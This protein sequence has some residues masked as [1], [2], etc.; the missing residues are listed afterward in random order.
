MSCINFSHCS[1]RKSGVFQ[2]KQSD[3]LHMLNYVEQCIE[4]E[5]PVFAS[6][7]LDNFDPFEEVLYHR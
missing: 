1:L 3:L 4:L 7:R 2:I 6:L 5:G